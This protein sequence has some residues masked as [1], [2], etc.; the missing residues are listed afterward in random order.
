[1]HLSVKVKT[2]LMTTV[3]STVLAAIVLITMTSTVEQTSWDS[4]ESDLKAASAQIL[5]ELVVDDG[6]VYAEDSVFVEDSV[7]SS[8]Y[9]KRER[10][11]CG[12]V[13]DASLDS[14]DAQPGTMQYSGT[15]IIYDDQYDLSGYGQVSIR[16][17]TDM[18]DVNQSMTRM[19]AVAA[20]AVVAIALLTALG[21][22]FIMRRSLKPLDKIIATT[23][24]I[25][26]GNNLSKRIKPSKAKDEFYQLGE[27]FNSMFD[28]LERS[29]E[30][31]KRFTNNA[32][33]EL[34]TP[35]TVILTQS[36]LALE[37]GCSREEQDAA[38]QKINVQ[39]AHMSALTSQ[40]LTIARTDRS[41]VDLQAS[42]V[43]LSEL[44]EM[45]SETGEG[46]ASERGISFYKRIQPGVSVH[47]NESLLIRMVLN[48]VENA[49]KYGRRGGNITVELTTQNGFAVGSVSDD[50]IGIA[51]DELD[52]IWER[53][54]QADQ[55]KTGSTRGCGLGLSIAKAAAVAHR[56]EISCSSQ[57]RKGSTFTFKLPLPCQL[58]G[59]QE[60]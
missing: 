57:P 51:P 41:G 23:E 48:L 31:E 55:A 10:F 16:S 44:M 45:V 9:G 15:W 34:R 28:R 50:G 52:S 5:A 1:M 46:L 3:F 26:S 58:N 13:P 6:A 17:V 29:F 11:L 53:F 36:E 42:L 22:Y 14:L 54:Y 38:L 59:E 39:A 20:A 24:H 19:R 33:H 8:V 30:A 32:A 60:R 7:Y 27:T 2:C 47:G 56:G 37:P 43:D 12:Y 25:S 49:V 35:I 4:A 18:Q 21:T 40:L